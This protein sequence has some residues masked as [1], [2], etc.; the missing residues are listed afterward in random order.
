M[1][2]TSSERS[3]SLPKSIRCPPSTRAGGNAEGKPGQRSEAGM[4]L[5]CSVR[6]R[7]SL[8]PKTGHGLPGENEPSVKARFAR[9]RRVGL[10]HELFNRREAV[11]ISYSMGWHGHR[12]W[13][14]TYS[15]RFISNRSQL[16][17]DA[18]NADLTYFISLLLLTPKS[19]ITARH[20][21][22]RSSTI[23]ALGLSLAFD[24]G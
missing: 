24:K 5:E 2:P 23:L 17:E 11:V 21:R 9:R 14:G 8:L 3:H 22:G 15:S 13:F 19:R 6:S 10:R 7:R 1:P 4:A 18:D 16:P 20:A 12:Y